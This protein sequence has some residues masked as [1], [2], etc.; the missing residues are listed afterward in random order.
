[1]HGCEHGPADAVLAA[2]KD[3]RVQILVDTRAVAASRKPG[4]SKR[5]L[6]AALDETVVLGL[7]TNL[8]FLRWAVR[9][10]IVRAG[11]VRVDTLD[12]IAVPVPVDTGE[13]SP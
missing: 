7:V 3:A 12:A 8:R 9:H 5:A 13:T 2:L 1:M 10:P 4:F 6:S 11:E